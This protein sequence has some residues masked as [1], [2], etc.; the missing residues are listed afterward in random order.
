MRSDIQVFSFILRFKSRYKESEGFGISSR[1]EYCSLMSLHININ[2][3]NRLIGISTILKAYLPLFS[4]WD[5][6]AICGNQVQ[7][8]WITQLISL[9]DNEL[10]KFDANREFTILEDSSWIKLQ[11]EIKDLTS[12]PKI[13]PVVDQIITVGNNKKQH[14]LNQ[15]FKLLSED[16]KK[17]VFDFGGGVGNLAYFLEKELEMSSSVIERDQKLIDSGKSKLL[18]LTP[19]SKLSFYQED[20]KSSSKM[21]FLN[22][23]EMAI[24]LH[25]CGN[26]ANNMLNVCLNHNV[27]KIINFGCCYSKIED[28]EYNIS[29]GSDKELKLNSRALSCAT[30]GFEKVPLDIYHYR[31]KIMD[32]K[33]SLYHWLFL[34]YKNK[35]FK[36]MSNSR[37]SLFNLD[38]EEFSFKALEKFFNHIPFPK[39]GELN[40]FYNSKKNQDL[41]KYF[42]AYYALSR[43]FGPLIE[44]YILIDRAL[45][46]Q[47]KGY[48]VEILEVFDPSISPRNKAI[49]A[50]L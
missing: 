13:S 32:Y 39:V 14:E 34:N 30:L 16:K 6:E 23:S 27:K 33:Y 24:G 28:D 37:R 15:L 11:N 17:N 26:F 19:P 9:P 46:L 44:S 2:F 45:Y 40:E 4:S 22:N 50:T 31:L 43:Y 21:P 5:M 3:Q 25:T 8:S 1:L 20:I 29:S 18:K 41:L 38:F 35:D 10:A 36:S 49:I 42:K 7:D 48:N 47:E 12:F